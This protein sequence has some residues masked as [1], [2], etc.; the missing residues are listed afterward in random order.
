[1]SGARGWLDRGVCQC[2]G[3]SYDPAFPGSSS[4]EGICFSLQTELLFVW[5][6]RAVGMEL[7]G[8]M[9]AARVAGAT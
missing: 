7:G 4:K 6:R 2:R 8:V 1:M 9:W 3:D 5:R